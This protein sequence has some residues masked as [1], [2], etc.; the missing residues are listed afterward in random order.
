MT[1]LESR[2]ARVTQSMPT[3]DKFRRRHVTRFLLTEMTEELYEDLLDVSCLVPGHENLTGSVVLCFSFWHCLSGT[4]FR[5]KVICVKNNLIP[6][7]SPRPIY[8]SLG[9]SAITSLSRLT[10]TLG[11]ITA[12][13]LR[14]RKILLGKNR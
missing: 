12:D 10:P 8:L 4:R 1:W 9:R 2:S 3:D 7:V 14:L 6:A 13:H 5:F 11:F